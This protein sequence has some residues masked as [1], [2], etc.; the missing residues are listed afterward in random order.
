MSNSDRYPNYGL[1]QQG[2]LVRI[3]ADTPHS[4]ILTFGGYI[5]FLHRQSVG[6]SQHPMFEPSDGK[7]KERI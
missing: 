1:N 5:R 6:P 2:R 7:I 3:D 4:E